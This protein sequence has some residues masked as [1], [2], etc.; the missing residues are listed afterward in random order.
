MTRKKRFADGGTIAVGTYSPQAPTSASPTVDRSQTTNEVLDNM[1]QAN[2]PT[3]AAKK[4]GYIKSADG[5]AQRGKT[6]GKY[7]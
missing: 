5:V 7:V 3:I 6:R 2:T 1:Q 4:G